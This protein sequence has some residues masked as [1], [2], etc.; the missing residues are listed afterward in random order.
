MFDFVSPSVSPPSVTLSGHQ[1]TP[2][3]CSCQHV[4]ISFFL[5]SEVAGKGL[6]SSSW[7]R[8]EKSRQSSKLETGT[9][10]DKSSKNR[11]SAGFGSG[12]VRQLVRTLEGEG[13]E[14]RGRGGWGRQRGTCW[15]TPEVSGESTAGLWRKE[16]ATLQ[17]SLR[18]DQPLENGFKLKNSSLTDWT[19]ILN[20][21]DVLRSLENSKLWILIPIPLSIILGP[22]FRRWGCRGRRAKKVMLRQILIYYCFFF[23]FF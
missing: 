14:C 21:S 4:L 16:E 7:H 18:L 11:A 3:P 13:V 6:I 17:T 2:P 15:L 22:H 9:K 8:F 23:F 1:Y 19:D 10:T 5:L 12:S 20:L